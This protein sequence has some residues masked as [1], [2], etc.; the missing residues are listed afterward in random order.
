MG[1]CPKP[2][3]PRLPKR[4]SRFSAMGLSAR[5]TTES[6]LK[7]MTLLPPHIEDSGSLMGADSLSLRLAWN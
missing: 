4:T 7:E 5:S 1:H 2:E 3:A 6:Q